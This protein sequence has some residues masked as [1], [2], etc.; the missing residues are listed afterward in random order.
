M[1]NWTHVRRAGWLLLP[2]MFAIII[3]K[4]ARPAYGKVRRCFD[5]LI[6]RRLGVETSKVVTLRELGISA[7]NRVDYEPSSWLALRRVLAERDVS[8]QDVFID[9]GCGK[10]RILIQAAKYPFRKIIGVELSAELTAIARRNLDLALPALVCRN[11][12]LVN[13]DVLQYEISDEI[14]VAYFYNPFEGEIFQAVVDKL[15]ASVERRPRTLRIIYCS[16]R[17]EASLLAA[18]ARLLKVVGGM[19]PTAR[20][21]RLSSI[22]LYALVPHK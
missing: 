1:P 22:R 15:V 11:I 13:E 16:P 5:A 8:V 2:A 7:S 9:F 10:G 3:S 18:G 17:E 12:E 19:R 6:E 14:T 21:S 4:I 20:W